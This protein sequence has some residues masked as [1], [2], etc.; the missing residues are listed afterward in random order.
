VEDV[1]AGV[2]QRAHAGGVEDGRIAG[3]LPPAGR[4]HVRHLRDRERGLADL[5]GLDDPLQPAHPIRGHHCRRAEE[6]L[7]LLLRERDQLLPVLDRAGQRLFA[8][9]IE[10]GVEEGGRDFAVER[11]GG[12]VD[13]GIQARV[14]EQIVETRHGNRARE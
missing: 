8:E 6:E 14:L 13:G 7:A 5:A 4:A 11:R 10:A 1:D 12:E 2:D 3:V 9:D